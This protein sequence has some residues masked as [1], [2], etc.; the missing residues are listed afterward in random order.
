MEA[1]TPSNRKIAIS[2]LILIA[3]WLIP[4]YIYYTWESSLLKKEGVYV[5]G[6]VTGEKQSRHAMHY[7]GTYTFKGKQYDTDF[8]GDGLPLH[9][10]SYF[11][12][13]HV[14]GIQPMHT[15]L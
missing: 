3:V 4:S 2:L 13:G 9:A 14:A 10:G 5:L 8:S 6:V 7:R 1:K 12:G 15:S 11:F